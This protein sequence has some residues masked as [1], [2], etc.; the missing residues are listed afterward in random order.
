MGFCLPD[1]FKSQ[2]LVQICEV[3]DFHLQ[4]MFLTVWFTNQPGYITTTIKTTIT[5]TAKHKSEF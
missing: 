1:S 5:T 3:H 2:P 4:V